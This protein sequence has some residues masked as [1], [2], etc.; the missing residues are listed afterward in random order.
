MLYFGLF[1]LKSYK[2]ETFNRRTKVHNLGNDPTR[3]ETKKIQALA[4]GKDK[5][6]VSRELKRNCD[7]RD[8]EYRADLAQ[9]KYENRQ[10]NKPKHIRFYRR[11]KTICR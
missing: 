8:R 4:I 10:K 11:S 5:S 9:R 1:P 3:M 2:D 7:N 6:V